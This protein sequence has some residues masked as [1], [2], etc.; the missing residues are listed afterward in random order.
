M[1]L[2]GVARELGKTLSELQQSITLEELLGWSAYF[3]IINEDQA[4]EVENIK[5]GR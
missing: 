3:A 4:K 1:L 5:N 2:F